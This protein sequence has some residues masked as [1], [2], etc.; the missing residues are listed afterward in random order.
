MD[1]QAQSALGPWILSVLNDTSSTATGEVSQFTLLIQPHR[2][3]KQPGVYVSVPPGGWFYDWVDVPPG[4]TNLTLFATNVTSPLPAGALTYNAVQLYEKLG[5]DPTLTDYDQEAGLTN[6]TPPGNLISVGPPLPMGR[7]FVGLYNPDVTI[8]Q[9]IYLSATLGVNAL[10][11]DIYDYTSGS[12]VDLPDD[13]VTPAP[14][15]IDG[16][17]PNPVS[18][19]STIMVPL[20]VTNLVATMNVGMVINSPRISDYAFTLVSPTGQRVLLMENRGGGGTN[21]AGLTFVYTNVLNST[22]T[23]GAAAQ[24]NYLAVMPNSTVPITWNFYTVPDQMTVYSTTN[25]VDFNTNLPVCIYNTGFTNN[26]PNGPGSQQ[27]I[28][29]TV[30]LAVPPGVSNIT[31]IM[32]QFGNPFAGSGDAWTYTAGAAITNY[33]Y[34]MF[35]DD[36]NLAT[37][38]IKFAQPP[39]NFAG[40]ATSYAVSNFNL[41]VATNYFGPTNFGGWTVPTNVIRISIIATNGSFALVTNLVVLTNNLVSVV[42]DPSTSLTGDA[43]G[44]NYLALGDGTITRSIPSVP[45][46][47]YNVTF[48]YRGPGIAGW[49]RG[50]G[51][52]NDSS[53]PEKNDNNGTLIGRFNFPA[54]EVDQAFE[55]EDQGN[56]YQFAGTNTYVQVPASPSLNVGAGGGFTVEGWI[57][58]TN[59]LRPQPLVE[60]LAPVPTNPAT[61]DTNLVIVQGPVLDPAT[62]HYYYLLSATNW[63]T[64]EL[65]AEQLNG[66]LVTLETANENQWVYDTFTAYGTLNRDL[67]TGLGFTNSTGKFGWS[68]GYTNLPFTNWAPAQPLNCSGSDYYVAILGPTNNYSGLWQ[69]E[70]NLGRTCGNPP[71]N[72][73]YGVVE[74]ATIPTNGVQFWISGTNW[75]PGATNTLQGCLYA[76]IV[77]TNSVSHWIYSAPGLLTTNVYQHVALTFNTNSGVAALYLNGTNVATSNLF[78]AGLSFV[79]KTGG[80]LLL[81]HDMTLYTNNFFGGEMDEMSVYGRALSLAEIHAIYDV[82]ALTTNRL[83][84]KFDPAITPAVG[85][86]EALVTFGS[87]SNLIYGV[88]NQ[89]EVNSFTFTAT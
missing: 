1:Y 77:D 71:T 36:T 9:E 87:S 84:G 22:A 15:P 50:E 39:F 44:S 75:T 5:N 76:N 60:W 20:G 46:L 69:L 11:N 59:L 12:P 2:D 49:W 56:T 21:G 42:S 65:W 27:T 78:T 74:V 17:T 79:P 40:V 18:A 55:F 43:G 37:V 8:S 85:L 34:L 58:P 54:G 88:N 23:G 80:D 16:A 6:G 62:S 52:A 68:S 67:W 82:S 73:I 13:A 31:I 35:T 57:N 61:A 29:V 25:P 64:S 51:N 28:R 70:D 4:Y 48:W 7:Y 66:H 10:V 19:G 81:G 14:A 32:N 45:G 53:D 33:E 41:V 24:T 89:W 83:I 3:L 26:P 86:A 72:P 63:L 30:D 38:P 47:T